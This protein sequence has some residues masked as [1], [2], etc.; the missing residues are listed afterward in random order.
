MLPMRLTSFAVLPLL[1]CS[2]LVCAQ[3]IEIPST[4]GNAYLRLCSPIDRDE[5]DQTREDFRNLVACSGY[6]QGVV[7]GALA[8]SALESSGNGTPA[9]FCVSPEVNNSQLVRVTLKYI[10][11]VPEQS[12]LPTVFLLLDAMKGAFPCAAKPPAKKQ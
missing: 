5:K 2:A 6:T 7:Q 12:H 3:E 11:K 9:P 1:L 8:E 10:R 4:S